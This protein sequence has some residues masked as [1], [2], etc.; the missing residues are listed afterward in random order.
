MDK[1]LSQDK[2]GQF[3]YGSVW[4]WVALDADTKLCCTSRRT[5]DGRWC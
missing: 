4:T 5:C 1:N 3:G 2:R